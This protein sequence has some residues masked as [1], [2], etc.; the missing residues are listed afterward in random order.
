MDSYDLLCWHYAKVGRRRAVSEAQ[1]ESSEAKKRSLLWMEALWEDSTT[2]RGENRKEEV[3]W[4]FRE[5]A[6]DSKREKEDRE[7]VPREPWWR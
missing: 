4:V 7:Y 2:I 3:L 6:R 5:L 1:S